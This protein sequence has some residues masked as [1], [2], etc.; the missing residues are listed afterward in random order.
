M[1][2]PGK[3]PPRKKRPGGKP[4]RKSETLICVGDRLGD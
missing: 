2:Y 3:L 4:V 1:M